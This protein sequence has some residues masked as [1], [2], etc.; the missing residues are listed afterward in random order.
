MR[1]RGLTFLS[2]DAQGFIEALISNQRLNSIHF[3]H[4]ASTLS[5]RIVDDLG[6]LMAD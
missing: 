2:S 6:R 1:I 4:F 3:Q 5:L